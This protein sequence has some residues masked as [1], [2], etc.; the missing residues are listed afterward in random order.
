VVYVAL[1]APDPRALP[2]RGWPSGRVAGV[3]GRAG[4][5]PEY[6]WDSPPIVV[7]GRQVTPYA[8]VDAA[9]LAE[10]PGWMSGLLH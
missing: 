10:R 1:D 6:P 3:L 4:M 2:T 7:N 9:W 8:L 5:V